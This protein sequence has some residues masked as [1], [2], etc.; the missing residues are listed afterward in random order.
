MT[1]TDAPIVVIGS[2]LAGYNLVKELR[3]LNPEQA[4]LII[5][6]DDGANYSKPMLS[7]GFTKDKTAEQLAMASAA[8]MAE[9]LNIVIRTHTRV[10]NIDPAMKKVFIGEEPVVYSKLVLAWGAD[11]VHARFE[12]D[13]AQRIFSVN[14]LHDYARFRRAAYGKQ[15]VLIMGAGLIGC[16]F[17]NDLA[18]GGIQSDVVAPC[19]QVLPGLLP[20]AAATAV[21]T[22]LES[23]G[24]RFHLGPLVSR[25]ET[26]E[27]GVRATLSNGEQIE[28]DLVLSAIGLRPRLDL[29]VKA[30]LKVNRGICVDRTL[31]TSEA[32][33]YALGD[34][35][36]IDGQV[37]LYVL[38][39]M[40]S[41]R[42]LAKTLAG[43]T[44]PVSFGPMPVTIK[45]PV[46]PVVVAPPQ[47]GVEGAWQI[48][49]QGSDIQAEFRAPGG[50][51]LGYALTGGTVS[52]KVALNKE[53]PPLLP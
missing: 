10:T 5:T 38:P 24:V 47:S 27:D 43:Q 26:T 11:V 17:A 42:A 19:D 16:E 46:V 45:T 30:G 33:I 15:R 39:L 49:G 50:E 41:A 21:Q 37:L 51:L 9:Q 23:L 2:G 36:E 14:D 25:I 48:D 4:I 31:Q 32:D 53:L 6:A 29:A 22:G 44:T 8:D 7:T 20:A 40:T 34:C 28:A 35:A 12:G 3:K 13:A 1:H 18:N 52:N